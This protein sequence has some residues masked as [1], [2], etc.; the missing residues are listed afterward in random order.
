MKS[1]RLLRSLY[2]SSFIGVTVLSFA[3]SQSWGVFAMADEQTLAYVSY[4]SFTPKQAR[5]GEPFAIQYAGPGVSI[6][7]LETSCPKGVKILDSET[8]LSLCSHKNPMSPCSGDSCTQTK[9]IAVTSTSKKTERATLTLRGYDAKGKQIGLPIKKNLDVLPKGAPKLPDFSITDIFWT[10]EHPTTGD[11]SILVT[12]GLVNEGPG[13]VVLKKGAVIAGIYEA[14]LA[15]SP[16][17]PNLKKPVFSFV[18]GAK[19]KLVWKAGESGGFTREIFRKDIPILSDA[20]DHILFGRADPRSAVV[21]VDEIN[22][23]YQKTLSIVQGSSSSLSSYTDAPSVDLTVNGQDYPGVLPYGLPITAEW[24][25][26]G[27]LSSCSASGYSLPGVDGTA[28]GDVQSAPTTGSKKLL[29]RLPEQY[30]RYYQIVITC[31]DL[32]V[33]NFVRDEVLFEVKR[34][35]TDSRIAS[36]SGGEQLFLGDQYPVKIDRAAGVTLP[37]VLSLRDFGPLVGTWTDSETFLWNVGMYKHR[38]GTEIVAPPGSYGMEISVAKDPI[39]PF[40]VL[41]RPF[42]IS[43]H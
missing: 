32:L 16:Y 7:E 2:V 11:A 31:R 8:G 12:I 30:G 22:N 41:S 39:G 6:F 35:A 34:G 9:K 18:L 24:K 26:K 25:A 10:P 3:F 5:H 1:S 23:D 40:D 36:P 15:A 19:D 4:F 27:P 21:E 37:F 14:D 38:N 33:N 20:G 43:S 28:W 42:T 13:N 17:R 29:P